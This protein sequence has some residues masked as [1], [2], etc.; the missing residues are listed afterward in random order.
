MALS[1][2]ILFIAVTVIGRVSLQYMLTGEH[3][4]RAA[5]KSSSFI[6][7]LSSLLLIT[8]FLVII[9]LSI[10]DYQDTTTSNVNYSLVQYIYSLISISGILLTFISQ[11]QMGKSWRVGVNN[12]ET[13]KLIKHGIYAYIRNPIFSGVIIFCF[14]VLLLIPSIYMLIACVLGYLS[15]EL[16]IRYAEEPYLIDKHGKEYNEYVSNTGRYIPKLFR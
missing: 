8:S 12:S 4:I 3:G 1:L 13:T 11:V 16:Q 10:L 7:K 9:I 2:L 6:Y 14:G 15:I 5:Q